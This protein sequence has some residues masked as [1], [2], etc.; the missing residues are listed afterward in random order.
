M[1]F[2]YDLLRILK[3]STDPGCVF[4]LLRLMIII[5]HLDFLFPHFD[6]ASDS[7]SEQWDKLQEMLTFGIER[8]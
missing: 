6:C 4:N 1:L 3:N 7:L 5:T 2:F 8:I